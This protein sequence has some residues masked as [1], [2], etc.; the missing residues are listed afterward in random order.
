VTSRLLLLSALLASAAAPAGELVYYPTH[1][2]F[3]GNAMN[4]GVLLNEA[5]AQNTYKDPEAPKPPRQKTPLEKFNEQLQSAVMNRLANAMTQGVIG[6]GGELMPGTVETTDF[7]ITI[8]DNGDGMLV[9]TTV[10]KN[11]GASSVFEIL[12]PAT[13]P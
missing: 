8:A 6:P 7:T 9:I 4:G 1:P 12:N 10:D 11:S 3:G 2:A 13:T 5:N